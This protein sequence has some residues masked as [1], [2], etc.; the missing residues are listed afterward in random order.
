VIGE[1]GPSSFFVRLM[2]VASGILERFYLVGRLGPINPTAFGSLFLSG[3]GILTRFPDVF[4]RHNQ[5]PSEVM[6]PRGVG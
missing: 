4:N 3:G 1:K 6:W 5:D 2:G